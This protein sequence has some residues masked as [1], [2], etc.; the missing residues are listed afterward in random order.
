MKLSIWLGS[1]ISLLVYVD[2]QNPFDF[3]LGFVSGLLFWAI[4][5]ALSNP[6]QE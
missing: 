3:L 1:F 6:P 4:W 5:A 2:G